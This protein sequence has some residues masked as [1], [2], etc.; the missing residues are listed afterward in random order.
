MAGEVLSGPE[1]RRRWSSEEKAKLVAEMMLPGAS[2]M[3]MS[4]RY[5]ISRSLLH[6]WRRE[7][8]PRAASDGAAPALSELVPI[9]ITDGV[10][11]PK[12]PA[13]VPARSSVGAK[14]TGTIEIALPGGVHVTVRGRIEERMLRAVLGALRS[15]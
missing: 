14:P 12:Q 6:A 9:M 11:P 5:G 4:R 7:A 8:N 10:E 15:M 13:A 2:V 1:R 3:E